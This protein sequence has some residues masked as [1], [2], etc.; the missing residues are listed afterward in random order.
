MEEL[1]IALFTDT[2]TPEVNGVAKTL[3]R[4]TTYLRKQGIAVQV[5]APSR[6]RKEA[7]PSGAAERLASIPFFLY[8]ELRLSVPVSPA[9]E[10]KLLAFRPTIIHVATPFGTGMA[11]RHLALKHGIPL[12]ASHHTHFDRYLPYYNLQWMGKL[13]WRYLY[14]FHRPCERILVPS[15]SVLEE[16]RKKGWGGLEVWSRAIDTSVFHPEVDRERLLEQA[17]IPASRHVVLSAGRLAPEK[18]T[19]VSVEAVARFASMT[20]EEVELVL[21]GEGPAEANIRALA[22]KLG[23]RATFLGSIPQ[24]E[25][26][27]WMAASSV[28][29]FPSP[30]ETFGNV[31]L[32]A[33]ACGLPVIGANAGAVPDTLKDGTNGLLCAPGDPDEFAAAMAKLR[34][35]R[36]LREKLSKAALETARSKSWDEVFGGL[37]DCVAQVSPRQRKEQDVISV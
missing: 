22:A 31:V 35:S 3:E 14:W 28:M 4:W 30:T 16:C 23:V 25:L 12:V 26:Q 21:A 7:A 5:F 34:A 15:P 36:E 24:S 32:E 8:P 20:G 19:E 6:P 13:L 2:Y 18:Q 33:M 10:R 29:L 37:L 11:G 27:K 17:G 1:R 9:A